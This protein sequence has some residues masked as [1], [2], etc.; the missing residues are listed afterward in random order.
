MFLPST[1]SLSFSK[2]RWSGDVPLA[3]FLGHEDIPIL[4]NQP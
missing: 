3:A 4:P 2:L 1:Y